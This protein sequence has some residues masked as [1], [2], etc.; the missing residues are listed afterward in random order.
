MGV[1][2]M[3]PKTKKNNRSRYNIVNGDNK[4]I[5]WSS[6][7]NM[8]AKSQTEIILNIVKQLDNVNEQFII[9]VFMKADSDIS[10]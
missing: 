3:I 10:L 2:F 4:K 6:Y 9:Y 1:E 8:L 5:N 7:N